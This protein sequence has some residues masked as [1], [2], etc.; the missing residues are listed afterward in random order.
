MSTDTREAV[1][2]ECRLATRLDESGRIPPHRREQQ[3]EYRPGY[4]FT[5]VWV[6]CQGSEVKID[7]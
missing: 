7:D 5:L 4:G 2:P 1:C 3:D 6:A